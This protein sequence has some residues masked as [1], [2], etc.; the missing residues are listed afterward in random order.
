MKFRNGDN[1]KIWRDTTF[2]MRINLARGWHK[3]LSQPAQLEN[4]LKHIG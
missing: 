3:I 1:D 2:R 4:K